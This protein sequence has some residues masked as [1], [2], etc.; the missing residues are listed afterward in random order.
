MGH[1]IYGGMH[2]A[3]EDRV[4]AHLQIVI[5]NKLRR[6]ESFAVSWRDATEVG[7]G[8]SAI[9]IDPSIPLYPRFDATRGPDID[10]AWLLRLAASAD[11][12]TGL[13]VTGPDGE[14]VNGAPDLGIALSSR[15]GNG[16][17]RV[18]RE[19]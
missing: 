16:S 7:D 6:S 2:V 4:L 3:F 1:L 15:R 18:R 9:W 8:R 13:I 19:R 14:P 5:V 11:S 12:S 10:R 17:T